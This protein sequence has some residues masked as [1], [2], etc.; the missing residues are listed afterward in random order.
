MC[1]SLSLG[2]WWFWQP[3]SCRDWKGGGETLRLGTTPWEAFGDSSVSAALEMRRLKVPGKDVERHVTGQS[4]WRRGCSESTT[5]VNRRPQRSGEA[6][7]GLS[8][9]DNLYVLWMAKPEKYE[10]PSFLEPST[11]WV[12]PRHLTLSVRLLERKHVLPW[13]RVCATVSGK[14]LLL[15]EEAGHVLPGKGVCATLGR[16]T[17]YWERECVLTTMRGNMCHGG[18]NVYYGEKEP[19]LPRPRVSWLDFLA[20]VPQ[21]DASWFV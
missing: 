4:R 9:G 12:N 20:L 3:E 14:C 11:S 2:W 13:E 1:K 21:W 10:C 5:Q 18:R 7:A 17:W 15:W 19:L 16:S 6:R 8:P